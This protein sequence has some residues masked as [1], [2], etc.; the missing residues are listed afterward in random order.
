MIKKTEFIHRGDTYLIIEPYDNMLQSKLVQDVLARGGL[1][2]LNTRTKK[3][4]IVPEWAIKE[5]A[6]KEDCKHITV[7]GPS[8]DAYT[9]TVNEKGVL[10]FFINGNWHEFNSIYDFLKGNP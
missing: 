7:C 5:Y 2:S 10:R 1:F 4:G 8:G 9:G 6:L 3:F